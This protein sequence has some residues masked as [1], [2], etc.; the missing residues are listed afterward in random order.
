MIWLHMID[1][2]VVYS[3]STRSGKPWLSTIEQ[4]HHMDWWLFRVQLCAPTVGEFPRCQKSCA[5]SISHKSPSD[6]AINR[7]AYA[8]K[9]SNT[10]VQG[11][12]VHCQSSVDYGHTKT[13]TTT[14]TKTACTVGLVARLCRSWLS[15]G[16]AT[17]I[18]HWRNPK[19]DNKLV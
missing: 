6:E 18:F 8:R 3:E 7:G 11:P 5:D 19:W 15:S 12:I 17:Q 13:T 2:S 10:H 1:E 9:G 14:T 16:K 4:G